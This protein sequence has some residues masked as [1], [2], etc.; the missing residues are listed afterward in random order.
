MFELF[1]QRI[2]ATWLGKLLIGSAAFL[3]SAR[4]TGG[5]Y[6]YLQ[7]EKCERPTYTVVERL[8][9]GVE[10]R[11]YDPYMIAEVTVDDKSSGFQKSG[12]QTFGTLAGYIFGRNKTRRGKNE[13]MAMTAPV[14][15]DGGQNKKTRYVYFHA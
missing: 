1:V 9:D 5:I 11:Q 12:K 15:F 13:K 4:Y 10:I 6:A 2:I 7:A 8:T 3:F 14:R